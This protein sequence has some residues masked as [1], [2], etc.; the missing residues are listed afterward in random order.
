MKLIYSS[1]NYQSPLFLFT[2]IGQAKLVNI[3]ILMMTLGLLSLKASEVSAN[4]DV[5]RVVPALT[6]T[7]ATP[8]EIEWPVTITTYGEIAPWEEASISAQIGGYQLVE[9]MVNVGDVVKKGQVL[10]RFNRA[11]LLMERAELLANAEQAKANLDRIKALSLSKSVSEQDLLEAKTQ[12]K[13]ADVLLAKNQLQLKYTDVTAPDDGVISDRSATVGAAITLG[14]ELFQMIRQQRLEWRGEVTAEQ[15]HLLR[16]G[17]T[18]S[19]SLPDGSLATAI[20]RQK[21]PIFESNTRLATVY[22][23]ISQSEFA[24]AGMYVSGEVILGS[25]VAKVVPA[26]SVIVRDGRN[27]VLS[28]DESKSVSKVTLHWVKTGR[29]KGE[30]VEIS[31][32]LDGV[33]RVVVDGAGF[34]TDGD[35]VRVANASEAS[36]VN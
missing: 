36:E 23:D 1:K 19:L 5:N 27:Y 35:V 11:L 17:Q 14:Q 30:Q 29:R 4:Q 24:V 3:L 25:S 20:I 12:E 33:N 28:I 34:L 7:S 6:V 8:K 15:F 2:S 21:S 22:A 10:A 32:G 9:V 26:K 16:A 13:V 18:V 31:S